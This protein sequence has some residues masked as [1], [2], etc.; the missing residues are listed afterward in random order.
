MAK[1]LETKKPSL[2]EGLTILRRRNASKLAPPLDGL[3]YRFSIWLPILAY[4]KAVFTA[5][6]RIALTRF[7]HD[8]FGGFTQSS[9]EGFPPWSGSW[10]PAG[11]SEPI[12]DQHLLLV[13]YTLQDASALTCMR[14]LKWILQQEHVA[15]QQVVLIE[16]V[17][18]RLI[19]AEELS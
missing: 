10:V 1:K 14:Q 11:S 12:V 15:A 9:L 13:V 18:V 5:A 6:H 4:G 19:E 7:F 16:Q 8:C 17:P 2:E 3:A